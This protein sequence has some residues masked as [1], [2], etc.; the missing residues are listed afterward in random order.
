MKDFTLKPIKQS[1]LPEK[2]KIYPEY[3]YN[4]GVYE[5]TNIMLSQLKTWIPY[6]DK[7]IDM[8]WP[9]TIQKETPIDFTKTEEIKKT[10][11]ELLS[12][13]MQEV[14]KNFY[15]N[16]WNA[17]TNEQEKRKNFPLPV[18]PNHT[19]RKIG[20]HAVGYEENMNPFIN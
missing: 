8:L 3:V 17:V 14:A 10:F 11:E 16:G 19:M 15:S 7:G 4:F 18:I 6:V 5:P 9:L 1:E 2:D 12:E 20:I 13:H